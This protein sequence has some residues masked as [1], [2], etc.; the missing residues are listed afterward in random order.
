MPNMSRSGVCQWLCC[1]RVPPEAASSQP[2][3][4]TKC[5]FMDAARDGA[6]EVGIH[7]DAPKEKG[8]EG[9]RRGGIP[10]QCPPR[11]VAPRVS[12][13]RVH[14]QNMQTYLS[15]TSPERLRKGSDANVDGACTVGWRRAW[16]LHRTSGP[17][18][19]QKPAGQWVYALIPA[20]AVAMH[21]QASHAFPITTIRKTPVPYKCAIALRGT[22]GAQKNGDERRTGS[23]L[24]KEGQLTLPKVDTPQRKVGSRETT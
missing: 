3:A 13:T 24:S 18:P 19:R 14:G 5:V 1:R 21:L 16:L 10:R 4:G 11:R 12:S 9:G 6:M 20:S 15:N 7:Q 17:N 23:C 2:K 8:H 22:T